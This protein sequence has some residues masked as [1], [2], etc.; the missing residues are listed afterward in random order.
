MAAQR[1]LPASY[2]KKHAGDMKA[3]WAD[4]RSDKGSPS[5]RRRSGETVIP[6]SEGG[7]ITSRAGGL[8]AHIA[9]HTVVEY[10]EE[11]LG[12]ILR[13]FVASMRAPQGPDLSSMFPPPADE[14]DE[15]SWR[16]G[17]QER[18]LGKQ[19]WDRMGK[20]LL[21][22]RVRSDEWTGAYGQAIRKAGGQGGAGAVSAGGFAHPFPAP[23]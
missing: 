15:A 19:L 17:A 23:R 4:Y 11:A 10:D 6:T 9:A 18:E 16:R 7:G 3:A 20:A 12:M 5:R 13:G 8:R 14:V 2:I 22:F 1:G 21:F